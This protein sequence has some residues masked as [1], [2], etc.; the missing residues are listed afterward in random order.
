M[1]FIQNNV[2]FVRHNLHL[3]AQT[4]LSLLKEQRVQKPPNHPL[5]LADAKQHSKQNKQG[6]QL[7]TQW[8]RRAG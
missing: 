1:P 2:P 8:S 3:N 5:N 4:K 6:W 7:K